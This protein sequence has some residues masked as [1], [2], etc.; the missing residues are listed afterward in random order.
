MRECDRCVHIW[1]HLTERHHSTMSSREIAE[2]TGKRHDH[3][4]IDIR[5]M[6]E[7]LDLHSPD[8]SGQYIDGTGRALTCFNLPKRETLILVS[9]YSIEL[10]ARIIN[11]CQI[12]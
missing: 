12:P 11:S 8:F 1:T 5:K 2:L 6:L 3:V 4:L 9:G 10:R 7:S